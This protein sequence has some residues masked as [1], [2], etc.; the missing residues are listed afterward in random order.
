MPKSSVG[1]FERELKHILSGKKD[2]IDK[3]TKSCSVQE[4]RKYLKVCSFPFIVVR[5][6]ASKGFADLVAL[7]GDFSFLVEIKS[8]SSEDIYFTR[9]KGYNQKQAEGLKT[10]CE[11]TGVLPLY[12]YRLKR[13]KGDSWRIYSLPL[14]GLSGIPKLV[15]ARLPLLHETKQGNY[16]MAW[17][18]GM[19]LSDFL[20]YLSGVLKPNL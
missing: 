15:H 13:I 16:I 8:S 12:A 1:I 18:S 20:D 3:A 11:K 17:D 10:E 2:I 9:D 5:A 6:A 7:R 4:K 14:K 19:K